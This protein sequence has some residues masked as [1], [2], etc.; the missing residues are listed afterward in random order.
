MAEWSDSYVKLN[1]IDIHYYRTGGSDKPQIILLHGVMDDGQGWIPVARD[2]QA[3]FDVIM[4]DARGHGSTGGSLETF[5]YRQLASDVAGLIGALGLAKPYLFGHSMGAMTA[6]MVAAN[7]PELVRAVVLEDPPFTDAAPRPAR[8]EEEEPR[9]LT[10]FKSIIALKDLPAEQRLAI[11][12]QYNPLW[13]EVE[14]A[15]WIESKLTFNPEVFQHLEYTVAWREVLPRITC[16]ILLVTGDPECYAIV[17]PQIA[18]EAAQLWRQ[19]EVI[20]IPRAGHCV[21]RDRYT[22]TMPQIEAFLSRV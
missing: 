6:A 20:Q 9:I 4:T 12:R 14:L 21:H 17:T 18:R 1:D 11:A 5:S 3:H 7:Y 10:F 13:D 16:P 8:E 15:P 2:L 22:Q 19:G